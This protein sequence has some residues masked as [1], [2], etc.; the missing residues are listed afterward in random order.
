M[1]AQGKGRYR[2]STTVGKVFLISAT[3]LG[4]TVAFSC[5][6]G[7][8]LDDF[9]KGGAGPKGGAGG[10]AGGSGGSGGT[11]GTSAGGGSGG[12]GASAGT[13][14]LD[15]FCDTAPSQCED[16]GNEGEQLFGC[17]EDNIR[18]W[19]EKVEQ[20]WNL[21]SENCDMTGSQCRYDSQVKAM[22]CVA[23]QGG[24]GG[25]GVCESGECT[26]SCQNCDKESPDC[27]TDT[28]T[29]PDHCG[30]CDHSCQGGKCVGG[31]CQVSVLA[32]SQKTPWGIAVDDT[33]VF[34]LA[35]DKSD[36]SVYSIPKGG[37]TAQKL[38]SG[39]NGPVQV[40]I[41]DGFVFWTNFQGGGSIR[42]VKKNGTDLTTL[43]QASGPW[44]IALNN[45]NV[46]WTNTSDG[47]IR[48]VVKPGGQPVV[49]VTGESSPRGIAIDEKQMYWTT[50]TGGQVRR[51][52][53]D[54]TSPDSL[55]AGQNYPLGIAV[56]DTWVYWTEVGASYSLGDCGQADGRIAR[57]KKA[58]G[59][60]HTTLA[61]NQ[62]C[63]LNLVVKDGLV[64]W[65]NAGTVTGSN[66]N[67]DGTIQQANTD[68]SDAKL[69]ATGQ[70]RPYGIAVGDNAIFWTNQGVYAGQGS[71][72]KIAR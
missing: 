13:G 57:A 33:T 40:A 38:A 30:K 20:K 7:E 71:V 51:A 47:S 65:V 58:D 1:S 67:Y 41:D 64:Y 14:G 27:E 8:S 11:G 56:D 36:G 43:A 61:S 59:S 37:G 28:N 16:L 70:D 31:K 6:L 9:T 17:C 34:W 12:S 39:Q 54:G 46:Y 15:V 21:R 44:A 18:W 3:I 22:R 25:S 48:R 45:D 5:R 52:N 55:V 32:A 29:N 35:E 68:G 53:L 49:L 63:P 23:G 10:G 42:R 24:T 69:V 2:C 50:S 26:G 60:S 4:V 72:M 66:Y 19:C 62:A